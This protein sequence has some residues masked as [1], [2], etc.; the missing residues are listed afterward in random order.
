MVG[1][2]GGSFIIIL[3]ADAMLDALSSLVGDMLVPLLD[4]FG[5]STTETEC[6]LLAREPLPRL[7]GGIFPNSD[8]TGAVTGGGSPELCPSYPFERKK[9]GM[10]SVWALRFRAV[11]GGD[12]ADAVAARPRCPRSPISISVVDCASRS[13]RIDDV[14]F[15]CDI[16]GG[17]LH[18]STCTRSDV[19]KAG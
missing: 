10:L 19:L 5:R 17:I 4:V 18:L 2:R 11:G 15:V 3:S 16:D 9:L 8:M 12:P 14:E 1:E 6:A 7:S 13:R